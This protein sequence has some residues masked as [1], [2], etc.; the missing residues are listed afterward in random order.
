MSAETDFRLPRPKQV[1]AVAMI[2]G[3]SSRKIRA[4]ATY[5]SGSAAIDFWL[6]ADWQGTLAFKYDAVDANTLRSMR[7]TAPAFASHKAEV[8]RYLRGDYQLR[9]WSGQR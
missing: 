4:S 5:N 8:E 2:Y 1:T 7:M 9:Y 6:E 3:E